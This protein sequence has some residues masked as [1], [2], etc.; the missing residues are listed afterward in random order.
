[1]NVQKR[2]VTGLNVIL[3]VLV[4]TTMVSVQ[5]ADFTLNVE[6]ANGDAVSGFRWLLQEDTTYAVDPANPADLTDQLSTNFHRSYH[7]P[8]Q[9]MDGEPLSGNV[10]SDSLTVTRVRQGRRYYLTVFPYS[11]FAMSGKPVTV[12]P[13]NR[14]DD[15]VTV[16][17]EPYATPTAQIAVY[18]FHD[19][20][21]LNGAP[22]LPE[23]TVDF[24]LAGV[25]V[26]TVGCTAL[27]GFAEAPDFTQFSVLV[28]E[29]AG[30][31]GISGGQVIQDPFGNPLGTVYLNQNPDTPATN[32]VSGCPV[33]A[34][35][36]CAD[37]T[38][39]PNADGTLI[40]KNLAPGKYGVIVTAPNGWTQTSTIEGSPVIDAW[41][42]ANEPP[43]M[44]EFG[45]P[46]PHVF[47]GFTQERD[48]F[49][50]L[51][52]GIA[53]VSG[54]ITDMHMSR[55]PSTQFFSGRPF[56]QCW[57]AINDFGADPGVNR[58]AGPCDAEQ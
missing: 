42:K 45:L 54:T 39:A 33:R 51:A 17:V 21:P 50:G 37:G 47:I 36:N 19:C 30:K 11:G 14:T 22:D 41:V 52:G 1:M 31:Y 40:I 10:A 29:P 26:G 38:L 7:P 24:N 6:D 27:N 58:Y 18:L 3:T 12:L 35:G 34:D 25:A 9:D 56:P 48:S 53:T 23:E 43:F 5:A 20:F 13:G 8:A 44:V 32:P 28:E 16:T 55:P 15:D 2:F 4:F 49:E 46:G 57:V